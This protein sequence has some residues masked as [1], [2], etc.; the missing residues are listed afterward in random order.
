MVPSQLLLLASITYA[1]AFVVPFLGQT[2]MTVGDQS[3]SFTCD[4]PPAIDPAGDGLLSAASL[5]SSDEAREKQVKR[6]QAIV[7]VPSVSYD[8]LGKI[9][10]DE[11][12]SPFYELFP[13]IQKLYPTL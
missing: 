1:S 5:F 9:G 13:V 6:H 7:R 4:L 12:W 11:R 10:E 8:D 2:P 3:P